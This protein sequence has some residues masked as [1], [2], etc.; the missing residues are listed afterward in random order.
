MKRTL[1]LILSVVLLLSFAAC[2][3]KEDPEEVTKGADSADAEAQV[4]GLTV[5]PTSQGVVN[6]NAVSIDNVRMPIVL[7]DMEYLLYENI[8]FNDMGSM[9]EDKTVTK[10]GVFTYIFDAWKNSNRYYVWGYY[11][12]TR[13]CDWQWEI[14]FGDELPELPPRGSRVTVTGT[15]TKSDDAL[16]GYWITSPAIT[17]EKAYESPYDCDVDMTTMSA[18]LER[19]EQQNLTY[20][21]EFFEGQSVAMYG[22]VAGAAQIQHP[23]YDGAWTQDFVSADADIP[24]IGT[25][26]VL[27]GKAGG[28]IVNGAE[29]EVSDQY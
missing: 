28:G 13:C 5:P 23:Y 18:T 16:D 10:T 22:R 1:I 2:G 4:D 3:G 17:V 19:V 26:V 9:Y 8:F 12:S 6:A 27:T 15:F 21:S 24:A 29:I 14:C 20:K 7:S 11:D 25:M